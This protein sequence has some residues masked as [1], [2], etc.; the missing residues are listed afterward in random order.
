MMLS[1][2]RASDVAL[3]L[4]FVLV[5]FMV[6]SV[7]TV[8][9]AIPSV[10]LLAWL[11]YRR[12]A[13]VILALLLWLPIEGWALKFVPGGSVLLAVPDLAS[14]LLGIVLVL[15]VSTG[16]ADTQERETVA[17]IIG[18]PAALLAVALVS[19]LV[20]RPPVVDAVYWV[21]V[22]L[23]F[24]PIA[25][26]LAN[27]E[28]RATV[29]RLLPGVAMAVVLSQSLVG[30]AEYVGGAPIAA[31]FWTGQY[32]LGVVTSQVDTLAT[33]GGRV[34]AGTL[35]HYNA[36]GMTLTLWIGILLGTLAEGSESSGTRL[37]SLRALVAAFGSL[38]VLLSQSRQ[39]TIIL[40]GVYLAW[41]LGAAVVSAK[42]RTAGVLAA[43]AAVVF[44]VVDASV[45]LDA[46]ASRLADL[47]DA[48]FWTVQVAKNRGYVVSG[49]MM[50]VFERAP[51]LGM[52]PGSF[53]TS[54]GSALGPV[55]VSALGLDAVGARFVGDVGW[56]ALFSQV[57][58]LGVGA[59]VWLGFRIVRV[60]R[61]P[62]LAGAVRYGGIA[63]VLLLVVGMLASTPLT[64]KGPSSAFWVI[65]GLALAL[66]E[67]SVGGSK[68]ESEVV[69]A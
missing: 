57:G 23:R 15:R 27:H 55:G 56:I 22:Y 19:W 26:S 66:H 4:L 54:Y 69:P 18:P 16:S 29:V 37:P 31:F 13:W 39:A 28:T 32:A 25:L 35:G 17:R 65:A 30:L 48:W 6:V 38:M 33:V 8:A 45:G 2:R 11:A 7:P 21:R 68:R 64:Y 5:G 24:V 3:V 52:G 53:G 61:R 10:L 9:L 60:L 62:K 12:P 44:V 63:A 34:V 1:G 58:G 36:Y 14:V 40:A 51:I 41:L 49:V 50:A 43:L 20:N 67:A 42:M 59:V 47:G 46:L